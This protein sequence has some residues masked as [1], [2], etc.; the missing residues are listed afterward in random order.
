MG[1]WYHPDSMWES[2]GIPFRRIFLYAL[3]RISKLFIILPSY[4]F[5][6][7]F[8]TST[9]TSPTPLIVLRRIHKAFSEP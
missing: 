9:T 4:L 2:K 6:R 5:L 7:T 8:E 1:S 3:S